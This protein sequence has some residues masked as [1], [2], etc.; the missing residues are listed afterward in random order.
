L[1]RDGTVS[2]IDQGLMAGQIAQ[3]VTCR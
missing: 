1:N 3:H 2:S